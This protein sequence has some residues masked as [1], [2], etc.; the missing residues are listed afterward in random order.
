MVRGLSQFSKLNLLVFACMIAGLLTQ[1]SSAQVART[2]VHPI[3]TMTLTDQQ[4]LTGG[5]GG[6]P[7]RV[8]G[9]LRIPRPGTER[10]PAV[11]LVHGSGGIRPNIDYWAQQ[12][13]AMGIATFVLDDFSGRGIESVNADQAKLG[14]LTAIIDV[15]KA[16]ALLAAH[17]RIDPNRIAVMGFSRGGQVAL[18]SSLIRFQRMYAAEGPGLAAYV[19]FYPNCTTRYLEDEA[20]A[21]KP[22]RLFHGTADDYNPL[23]PCRTYVERLRKAGKDVQLTEYA[24]VHHA[25]DNPA[26]QE[27]PVL[28]P[29]WQTARRCTLEEASPGRIVNAETKQQ[30]TWVDPC[31]ELGPHL[32][33]SEAALNA[34]TQSV[35]DFFR[36][37]FGLK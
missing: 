21:A 2:E 31:V 27:T 32:G 26:P 37:T 6:M 15:Y 12:F 14:R 4:F 9:V 10:L 8:A 5:K 17:S 3:Q 24:N 16:L 36:V 25:F 7:T 11:I 34:S 35:K 29:T 23:T 30:F 18:Y 22:I 1:N 20:V 33:Y 19:A 28:Y 13:N